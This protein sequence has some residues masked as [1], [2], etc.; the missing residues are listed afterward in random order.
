MSGTQVLDMLEKI[1]SFLKPLHEIERKNLKQRIGDVC[2]P[3]GTRQWF[4]NAIKDYGEEHWERFL[5]VFGEQ[6]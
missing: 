2:H 5:E 4:E 1:E 3:W 6:H